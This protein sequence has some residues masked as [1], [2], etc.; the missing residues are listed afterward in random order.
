M[1]REAL[2]RFIVPGTDT[3]I[4]DRYGSLSERARG[5]VF[6][7]ED[8]I[9]FADIET[10]GVD[11]D[12]DSIIEVA[13]VVARGPEIID[14]FSTLVDPG[15]PIPAEISKLTGIT[16]EM[17]AGSPTP[18]SAAIRLAEFVGGRD[19]VAHN[20]AFDRSFL[21]RVAPESRFRGAWLDSVQLAVIALPRLRSHRLRD[22][23][24]AFGSCSPSHRA[25]DDAEALAFV[26]RVLLCALSDFPPGLLQRLA[27][28][29][30]NGE[31]SLRPVVAHLAASL[32]RTAPFDIK[33]SRLERTAAHKADAL[34]DADELECACPP[35]DEVISEFSRE[36]IAGRMYPSFENRAEQA[37][38]ASAVLEAFGSGTHAAI[39]AGTGVGKSVAYLVPAALF[40]QRNQVGVGIATKTNALMDQLVYSELP[41]LCRAMAAAPEADS[42]V[43]EAHAGDPAEPPLRY[44]ALKGYEH[45]PCLR[46]LDR[47]VAELEDASGERP[48]AVAASMLAWIAQSSWGDLDATNIH[49]TRDVKGRI[50]ASVA[51]CTHRRCRYYPHLCYLHGVRRKA[52]AAH[53]VVTNHALLFR[54]LVS[55]GGIL[56][57]IRH[58][59]IDEAHSA[60]S[61]ARKQLTVGAS[62]S[63]L[64]AALAALRAAGRGGVLG[65]L[66]RS[67]LG[68]P[69]GDPASVLG[70]IEGMERDAATAATLTDSLFD[71]VKDLSERTAPSG[72]DAVELRITAEVRQS[73]G[74]GSVDSVGRSLAKRLTA[75]LEQ[76]RRLMTQLEESG[77]DLIAERADLV[78]A[79]SRIA[80]QLDGLSTVLDGEED[81]FVYSAYTDR[82]RNVTPERLVAAQLDVGLALAQEFFPRT[83]SVVFTSATIAA[84]EDFSHFAHT[85]GLDRLEDREWRPLRLE[86]SYDF[87]RQMAVFV[88]S[89]LGDPRGPAYVACLETLL[90]QVHLA[91]GGSV[92]TLF[93]NRRDMESL[94]R[95]LEPR[96]ER[97]GLRLLVQGRGVSAKRLRDEF[98][99]DERLSLF[100]TK[101]FWEGFDAKGD[102]LRCVVVPRLPFGRPTDPLAEERSEREGRAAWRRYAL[103]EAI[104][105]LKQA[106]GRLIRSSTDSGCLVIADVRVLTQSYGREFL[107]SLPVCD[108]EVLPTDQVT[109]QIRRRFRG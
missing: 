27:H 14:R 103:P 29:A 12:R 15:C 46:K 68:H 98:L 4:A 106:A 47:F 60:E 25:A 42:G 79:L 11:P 34:T 9:A 33:D 73:G 1:E 90:E 19:I 66:R 71:F 39:E 92:L 22:L 77:A 13:A 109:E 99:A 45:Y 63:E 24:D 31:W 53:I 94:Y 97:A 26:W 65:G 59:V 10:T 107:E 80:E 93:T 8:E 38:M 61:E 35:V 88:P 72:Y 49:W 81:S 18:E 95:I 100:A 36:G 108:V 44:V 89:D 64:S 17:V 67:L 51:D 21:L 7:F 70:T 62:H 105:E 5:A 20:A 91:M 16:D 43:G 56:P 3:E 78:G 101:S 52:A 75:V 102:T 57:P 50:A 74:W 41:A 82:R 55:G 87:E 6:G 76:G 37:R 48:I 104:I 23:A 96:L 2:T 69:L 30:P 58:W 40:A 32:G 28:L 86:S 84:G 54:D 85:V 83:R